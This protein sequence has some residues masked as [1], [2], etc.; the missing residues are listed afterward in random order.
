MIIPTEFFDTLGKRC[1]IYRLSVGKINRFLG[2]TGRMEWDLENAEVKGQ[3]EFHIS[4]KN[5]IELVRM[6]VLA[7]ISTEMLDESIGMLTFTESECPLTYNLMT[8]GDK[9]LSP[10]ED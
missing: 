4:N 1:R 3:R 10:K 5:L 8:S 9:I 6:R 2:M 7:E